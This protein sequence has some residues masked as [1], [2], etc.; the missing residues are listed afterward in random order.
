MQI[1]TL[2]PPSSD[3]IPNHPRFPT[4]IY[5]GAF[6]PAEGE[7]PEAIELEL[8]KH[9]WKPA[10]RFGLHPYPHFHSTTHEVIAA[11]R[12]RAR[13]R[14]GH[15]AGGEFELQAG[16]VVLIPA[17]VGHECVDSSGRFAA[18]GAYPYGFSPDVVTGRPA[19]PRAVKRRVASVARPECDPVS[20]RRGPMLSEWAD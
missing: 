4:I 20:G 3:W 12:G 14:L 9:G 13:V 11:Y 16:D 6:A 15:A 10:W 19:D 18:V 8:S 1:E 5:R 7:N 17:G 2:H